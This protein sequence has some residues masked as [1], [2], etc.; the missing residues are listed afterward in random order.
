MAEDD[1]GVVALFIEVDVVDVAV[2]ISDAVVA[3]VVVKCLLVLTLSS[4]LLL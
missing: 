3:V 4:L 1:E 2:S